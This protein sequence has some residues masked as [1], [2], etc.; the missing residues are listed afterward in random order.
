MHKLTYGAVLLGALHYVMLAKG[1]QIEP[2]I[3]LAAV[4][5]LLALRLPGI[6]V[7]RRSGQRG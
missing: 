3:Y 1:F 4:L 5:G 7:A 2:L 6:A